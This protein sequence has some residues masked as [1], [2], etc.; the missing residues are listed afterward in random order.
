MMTTFADIVLPSTFNACEGLTVIAKPANMRSYA[1][2]QQ[3]VVKR[4]WDLKQE[5]TE[6]VWL[7]AARLEAK[8]LPN[9]FDGYSQEFKDPD[10]GKLPTNEHEFGEYAAKTVITTSPTRLSWK[11]G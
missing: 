8:G 5:E 4:M 3:P 2:I 1:S 10:T 6:V 7:L 11:S 9:L